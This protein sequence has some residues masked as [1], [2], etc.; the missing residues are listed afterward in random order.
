M[1]L[2]ARLPEVLG[3][4]IRVEVRESPERKIGRRNEGLV[5]LRIAHIAPYN[6]TPL[7]L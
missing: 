5:L 3:L 4:A 7:M 6:W 2:E 1:K